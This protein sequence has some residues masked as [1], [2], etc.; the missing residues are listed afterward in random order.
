MEAIHR[1]DD[2]V[3]AQFAERMHARA[4]LAIELDQRILAANTG[5]QCLECW[6]RGAARASGN[7]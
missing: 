2:S 3:M 5:S 6:G 1:V 4:L 7:T